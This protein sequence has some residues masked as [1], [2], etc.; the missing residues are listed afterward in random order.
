MGSHQNAATGQDEWLT[1]PDLLAA[2]GPFDLDPC[3]PLV[4]PWPTAA[5]HLTA[6]DDGLRHEWLGLVWLNPPYSSA[7]RW[8]HRLSIHPAGG[9]ALLFART[10]TVL[11]GQHVWPHAQ[12]LLFLSGR[13]HFHHVDGRRARDNAGAPSALIAY[14]PVAAE[15]LDACG[16]AGA[17]ASV[18]GTDRRRAS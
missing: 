17:L 13:L 3:A 4:R 8:L 9:V 16:L 18:S 14:G 5:R 10:E 1:P 12:R 15:R 6:A 11:W 2:L 7:A